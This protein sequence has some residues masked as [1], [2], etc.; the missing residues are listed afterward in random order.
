M[1]YA[2]YIIFLLED[3]VNSVIALESFL[4]IFAQS[5]VYKI[6]VSKSVLMGGNISAESKRLLSIKV[7]APWSSHIKYLGIRLTDTMHPAS[8]LDPNLMPIIRSTR[9]HLDR[10]HKLGLT[11]LGCVVAVKM[12][13]LPKFI[14]VF[15]SLILSIPQTMLNDKNGHH[16]EF[17]RFIWN[18]KNQ[19]YRCVCCNKKRK[20]EALHSLI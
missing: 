7:V 19:D 9:A 5:T 13:I 6:N 14:F 17:N 2:D 15:C 11:W 12:V 18:W 8:L 10:W 1:L 16:Y 20:R 3:P 4:D